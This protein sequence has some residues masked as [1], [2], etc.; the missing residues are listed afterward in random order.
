MRQFHRKL[1]A[2]GWKVI[3][4]ESPVQYSEIADGY[5]KQNLNAS[6]CCGMNELMKLNAF[7]LTDYYRV[8]LL[9]SDAM[10]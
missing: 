5:Y 10:L 2:F 6:G 9:D 4:T 7:T 3:E 1:K 8:I